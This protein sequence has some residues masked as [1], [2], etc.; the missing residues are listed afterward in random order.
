MKSSQSH[1]VLAKLC[2]SELF[3]NKLLLAVAWL[4]IL[5]V[6]WLAM[7]PVVDGKKVRGKKKQKKK[8]KNDPRKL[9]ILDAC[10]E[11]G[12][13]CNNVRDHGWAM[14]Y[15]KKAKDG[16]EEQLGRDSEKALYVTYY[17]FCSSSGSDTDHRQTLDTV[18]NLGLVYKSLGNYQKAF[19]YHERD[20]KASEKMQ[21]VSHPQTLIT[22]MNMS[23][24]Y[25]ETEDFGKAEEYY[26]RALEGFEAQL[27]KYN[28]IT[29][30][31]VRGIQF[32]SFKSRNSERLAKL[33]VAY[34][35]LEN[36]FR[37]MLSLTDGQFD[38]FKERKNQLKPNRKQ[39]F[40]FQKISTSL[41]QPILSSLHTKCPELF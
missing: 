3:D 2:S 21:G 18:M 35:W 23:T 9:E 28:K 4:R 39:R 41:N 29:K 40:I 19:E 36:D 26:E 34:P 17:L 27:G 30:S 13:A 20:L 24:V 11:T 5:E 31:C 38:E 12:K 8:T 1:L 15:F 32:C 16:C 37:N 6:L 22:V 7:Q 33:W 10:F 14:R 25:Y